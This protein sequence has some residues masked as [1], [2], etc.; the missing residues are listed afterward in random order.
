[1]SQTTEKRVRVHK[2]ILGWDNFGFTKITVTAERKQY[3]YCLK[4][5]PFKIEVGKICGLS[6]WIH[7]FIADVYIGFGITLHN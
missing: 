4:A 2:K 5:F 7:F 6:W 3:H 1:M